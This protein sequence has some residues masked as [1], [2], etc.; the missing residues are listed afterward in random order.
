MKKRKMRHPAAV[1]KSLKVRE[2]RWF[3]PPLTSLLRKHPQYGTTDGASGRDASCANER[4]YGTER[5][6]RFAD[7]LFDSKA[8]RAFLISDITL[9]ELKQAVAETR[10]NTAPGPDR[11]TPQQLRNL[12]DQDYEHL[13]ALMNE[14]QQAANH[15]GL[16]CAPT[17]SE[18]LLVHNPRWEPPQIHLEQNG[19]PIPQ[20]N[21]IRLLGLHIQRDGGG[22]T[23]VNH[24]LKQGEQ[25]LNLLRR[26]YTSSRGLK[27]RSMMRLCD[28]LLISRL[29]YHLPY[30]KLTKRQKI[31]LDALIRK[32]IKL[33][34]GLPVTTSTHRLLDMGYHN[35][36]DELVAIHKRRQEIRLLLTP[37]GRHIL[38]QLGHNV[39]YSLPLKEA[40][41]PTTTHL[42]RRFPWPY[43]PSSHI[44]EPVE[45]F[46]PF[47]LTSHATKA[48]S[49]ATPKVTLFPPQPA[50]TF[51]EVYFLRILPLVSTVATAQIPITSY[52]SAIP[53]LHPS[54]TPP[55]LADYGHHIIGPRLPGCVIQSSL[56]YATR[57]G[58]D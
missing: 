17:K 55:P 38:T 12:T 49:S 46:P 36:V 34:M 22:S 24:F 15:I 2:C 20:P 4:A 43:L 52:G 40:A 51:Y 11:I 27:E 54:L 14:I 56:E 10:V 1:R 45:S 50:S 7:D 30:T 42:P 44:D 47:T 23:T 39:P 48:P 57:G 19:I 6:R 3:R 58:L 32:G 53:S 28:A 31:K 37:Q 41:L 25:V 16:Q 9:A 35:T 29:R 8:A 26:V 5:R 21:S 33:A 13:L 18:L